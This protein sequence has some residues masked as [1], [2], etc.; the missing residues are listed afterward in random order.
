MQF[1][2]IIGQD[3]VKTKLRKT[4]SEG[5]IGHAQLFLGPEGC[6]KLA[7][8][9][10]FATYISCLDRSPEDSCGKCSS[11]LKYNKLVHPDLHLIFP[12]NTGRS[13]AKDPVSDDY[14]S[15]WRE[16]FLQ[17]PYMRETQWYDYIG[18]ENKQGFIG[19]DESHNILKRLSLKPFE[20]D[21]KVMVI[22][23]PEKMNASAANKLLKIIEEPPGNTFFFMV[24]EDSGEILST[25]L[26]RVQLIKIPAI[27]DRDIEAFLKKEYR[28][29]DSMIENLVHLA[30]GNYLKLTEFI[31]NSEENTYNLEK[32]TELMRL[33]YKSDIPG[34]LDLVDEIARIGREKQKRLLDY[35]QRMIRENYMMNLKNPDITYITLD[36]KKFSDNFHPYVNDRNIDMLY[37]L[38][39]NASRDIGMNANVR[40]VL[41]DV[42]L[43]LHKL[44]KE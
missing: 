30:N 19:V 2:E 8:A 36:E 5:K 41:T 10:A 16:F 44:L 31:S 1:R 22:W 12:V 34:I 4:V 38:F 20:S 35:G 9:V 43:K 24:T 7:M 26:S 32:F 29:S 18:I 3:E 6:G 39:N 42:A 11:C 23:L 37:S 17:H 14:I 15:Q 28:F 25:I 40:V 13:V 21:Y 33:S 27:S